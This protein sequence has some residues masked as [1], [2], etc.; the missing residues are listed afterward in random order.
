MGK[1]LLLCVVC[2]ALNLVIVVVQADDIGARELDDFSCRATDTTAN[3][4]NPHVLLQT[5]DVGQ[6]VLMTGDGLF[7]RLAVR[8]SAEVE[9]GTPAV[10]VK[11]GG[12]VVVVSCEGGIFCFAGLR[13]RS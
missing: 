4:Q 13:E 5:H 10:L 2:G 1:S 6:V 9:R 12:E 11:V 8:E 3:I 7:E